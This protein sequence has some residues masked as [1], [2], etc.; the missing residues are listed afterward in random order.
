[1]GEATHPPPVH[2]PLMHRMDWVSLQFQKDS[3]FRTL[4]TSVA[5]SL[6][7]SE[8]N[9]IDD[10]VFTRLNRYPDFDYN[11]W[12][13]NLT[14]IK[15]A[16]MVMALVSKSDSPSPQIYSQRMNVP[17]IVNFLVNFDNIECRKAATR[18][19]STIYIHQLVP[20]DETDVKRQHDIHSRVHD[21]LWL[22]IDDVKGE[23]PVYV[24][25]PSVT[26]KKN[27][28]LYC[29]HPD[30]DFGYAKNDTF[31]WI[32]GVKYDTPNES[33]KKIQTIHSSDVCV[34]LGSCTKPEEWKMSS[35]MKSRQQCYAFSVTEFI[36]FVSFL[37]HK[38]PL[39]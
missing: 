16:G 25:C 31:N 14:A 33:K 35:L 11:M 7:Q 38:F 23:H 39:D 13:K 27:A 18:K 21:C 26:V 12:L 3:K 1:M 10:E 9:Y 2:V 17:P 5:K 28:T 30:F 4:V 29:Y 22:S 19:A 24:E 36:Q 6:S 34:G 32:T 15:H 20:L 8:H 37:C